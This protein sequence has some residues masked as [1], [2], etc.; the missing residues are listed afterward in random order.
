MCYNNCIYWQISGDP[1]DDRCVRGRKPCPDEIEEDDDYD[2]RSDRE[3]AAIENQINNREIN[4][5]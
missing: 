4:R 1:D 3:D 2:P 5:S